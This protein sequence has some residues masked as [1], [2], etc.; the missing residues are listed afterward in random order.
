MEP[1][2]LLLDEPVAG[3]NAGEKRYISA[4]IVEI[5]RSLSITVILVEHDMEMVMSIS[6]RVTVLDF[7]RR[8]A[9]GTPSEVQNDPAVIGAY[10][11]T[12]TEK[13]S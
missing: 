8:I 5:A 1:K 13:A 4:L 10:L 7:G 9:D 6:D 12:P 3:M 11:G 2:V